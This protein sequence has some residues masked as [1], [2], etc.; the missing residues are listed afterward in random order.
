MRAIVAFFDLAKKKSLFFGI[1]ISRFLAVLKPVA[2]LSVERV[3][4]IGC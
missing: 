1:I 3:A 2:G 4:F